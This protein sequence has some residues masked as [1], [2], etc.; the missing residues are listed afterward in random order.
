MVLF[1]SL[2]ALLGAVALVGWHR[3]SLAESKSRRD[4]RQR[5]TL[6][7]L[8]TPFPGNAPTSRQ[9]PKAPE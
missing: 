7:A 1:A 9:R 6:G 2:A 8:L 4:K 3:A 5:E